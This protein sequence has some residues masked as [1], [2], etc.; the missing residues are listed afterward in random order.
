MIKKLVL[1]IANG[2]TV[3]ATTELTM[4]DWQSAKPSYSRPRVRVDNAYA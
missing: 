2:S 3:K 4:L 1:H